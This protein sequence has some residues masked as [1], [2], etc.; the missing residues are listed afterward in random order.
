MDGWTEG[1][2]QHGTHTRKCKQTDRGDGPDHIVSMTIDGQIDRQ[3][4][5]QKEIPIR[6]DGTDGETGKQ[7]EEGEAQ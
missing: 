5:R 7:E 6:G 1:H 4:D 3:T 2:E